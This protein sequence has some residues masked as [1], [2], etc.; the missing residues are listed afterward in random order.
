[1][2]NKFKIGDL[3]NIVSDDNHSALKNYKGQVLKV[4][5]I[6]ISDGSDCIKA[7]TLDGF[8]LNEGQPLM[9]IRFKIFT[10]DIKDIPKPKSYICVKTSCSNICGGIQKSLEASKNYADNTEN[11]IYELTPILKITTKK[12]EENL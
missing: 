12:V 10:G 4:T 11:I 1:M 9:E 7:Q 8:D 3:V 5:W 2:T 6:G